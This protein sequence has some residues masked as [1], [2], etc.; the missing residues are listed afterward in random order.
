MAE[1]GYDEQAGDKKG[2]WTGTRRTI[3]KAGLA[4]FGLGVAHKLFRDLNEEPEWKKAR[5]RGELEAAGQ[6]PEKEVAENVE[7]K[8]FHNLTPDEKKAVDEK[9]EKMKGNFD[10]HAGKCQRIG[11]YGQEISKAAKNFGLPEELLIGLIFAESGGK[12]TEVSEEAKAKGLTQVMDSMAE[13]WA[14]NGNFNYTNDENDDRYNVPKVLDYS[15]RE[16]AGY[17]EKFGD[18]GLAFWAWHAGEPRVFEAVRVYF[19]G[20]GIELP[21]INVPVGGET[22]EAED[23]AYK[24][25]IEIRK[26]YKNAI[27]G[28]G[29]CIHHV[30]STEGV[31][32]MF[33]GEEWNKTD[34]YCYRICAGARIYFA[35][36]NSGC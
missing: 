4:G 1:K 10:D 30:L 22:S 18:W 2:K 29:L 36:K 19:A 34:E 17:F 5:E 21:D 8:F 35:R 32:K 28:S 11:Q 23:E 9:I 3:L 27:T 13:S 24:K 16:I 15:C 7:E 25:A 20:K 12:S 6:K 14:K 26:R 31:K 33:E